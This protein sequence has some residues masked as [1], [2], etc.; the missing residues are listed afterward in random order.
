MIV[1]KDIQFIIWLLPILFMFHDFE[2]IIFVKPWIVKSKERLA[3]KYP[4]FSKKFVAHY[5]PLTTSSFALGVA[6]EFILVSI[7]TITAFLTGW[8]YL[9]FGAFIAFTIHLIAHCIQWIAFKGYVPVIVTS[10]IC[11]PICCYCIVLFLQLY[12]LDIGYAVLFSAIGI[13]ITIVN[14][15]ALH[16]A[17]PAFDKWLIKYQNSKKG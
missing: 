3:R 1:L 16:K 13:I 4:K 6:E 8:Y 5:D 10:V 14:L 12:Q 9:W 17:M 15:L 2:E 7:I 11:L